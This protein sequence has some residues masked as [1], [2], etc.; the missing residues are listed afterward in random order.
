MSKSGLP[1]STRNRHSQNHVH[2]Q[3]VPTVGSRP[4][5]VADPDGREILARPPQ[6]GDQGSAAGKAANAGIAA[7]AAFVHFHPCMI[8][9]CWLADIQY[10]GSREA[11]VRMLRHNSQCLYQVC[12]VLDLIFT[13]ITAIA[14]IAIAA[15]VACR[16]LSVSLAR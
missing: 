8:Y 14:L 11:K 2:E 13:V 1:A 7:L 12:V 9:F 15:L 6:L 5:N 10:P 4:R 3:G 16:S